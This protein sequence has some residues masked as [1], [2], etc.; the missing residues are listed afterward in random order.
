MLGKL[1]S[2]MIFNRGFVHSDPHPGK[3]N[4]N[5]VLFIRAFPESAI[6]KID[7]IYNQ[8]WKF[9][10]LKPNLGEIKKKGFTK[11]SV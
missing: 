7:E 2:E 4:N 1:Y 11:I 9:S 3:F 6:Q 10:S 8:Y 5:L